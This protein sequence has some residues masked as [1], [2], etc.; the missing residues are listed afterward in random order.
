VY[1]LGHFAYGVCTNVD[2]C[3]LC[4]RE[5]VCVSIS[6]ELTYADEN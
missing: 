6:Q 2:L 3:V 1:R 5:R 4:V